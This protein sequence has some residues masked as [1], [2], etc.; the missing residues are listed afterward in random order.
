MNRLPPFWLALPG[1]ASQLT[2]GCGLAQQ[3]RDSPVVGL[4]VGMPTAVSHSSETKEEHD[5]RG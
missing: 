5:Y 3:R 4:E 2:A 1:W